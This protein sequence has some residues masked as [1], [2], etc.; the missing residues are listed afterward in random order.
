[1]RTGGEKAPG[2]EPGVESVGVLLLVILLLLLPT[3]VKHLVSIVI[4]ATKHAI[5]EQT[6]CHAL[7]QCLEWSCCRGM[8]GQNLDNV[9]P[10]GHVGT[11]LLW[12]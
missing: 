4:R 7:H 8:L 11:A 1:M 10:A 2:L 9:V 6:V 3:S 5:F 12:T